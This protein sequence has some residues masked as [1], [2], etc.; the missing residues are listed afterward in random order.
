MNIFF[1]IGE[2]PLNSNAVLSIPFLHYIVVILASLKG[3][4]VETKIFLLRY[5]L[6]RSVIFFA[7][8]FWLGTFLSFQ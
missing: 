1:N 8:L 3:S 7:L 4:R 6:L 2:N 5:Q